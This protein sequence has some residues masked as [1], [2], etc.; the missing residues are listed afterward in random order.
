MYDCNTHIIEDYVKL[1]LITYL[2]IKLIKFA[3][4]T[5][6]GSELLSKCTTKLL[7]FKKS[8]PILAKISAL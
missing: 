2:Y 5:Q 6:T 1:N 3:N 4:V 8:Y 7:P